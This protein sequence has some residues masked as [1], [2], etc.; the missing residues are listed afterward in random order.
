MSKYTTG[1]VAKICGVSVRTVQYYDTR[2]ILIPSELSDGG[3]RLYSE[4]DL[5]RMKIICFLRDIGMPIND[6]GKLLSEDNPQDVI[7]LLLDQQEKL[8]N[9]E[10]DERR[11]MLNRIGEFKREMKAVTDFSVD[12]IGDIAHYM[13]DKKKL[14]RMRV[15]MVVLGIPVT[16]FQ[17]VAV[18]LLIS[19][20]IWWPFLLWLCIAAVYGVLISRYYFTHTAYICPE[21]HETFTARFKEVF[22]ANH[23]PRARRLRCPSCG[24]KR[25][26]VEVYANGKG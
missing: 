12:S 7:T 18:F 25:F 2:S 9:D 17:W 8:L 3:R 19:N 23:T 15:M 1:E 5:K 24:V 26:C 14:S 20:G 11:E 4:N 6:I 22:W 21:C 16:A 13:N 10:M